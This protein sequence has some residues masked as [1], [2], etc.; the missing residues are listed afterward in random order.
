M[1]YLDNAATTRPYPEVINKITECV[2]LDFGNPSSVH[3]IGIN[4]SK[5]VKEARET[6]A[7]LF[8]VPLAGS[9]FCGSGT[10]ADNL[11]I[12]GALRKQNNEFAGELITSKTEHAA[13]LK[14]AACLEEGGV[15][16]RILSIDPNTGKVELDHLKGLIT[17][18][19][20]LISIQHVNSETGAIHDLAAISKLVKSI[21]SKTLVH[22]D[23]V[24]AF[25]KFPVHLRELGIDM[26]SISGHKFGGVK[27]AGALIL[28][29]NI[30]LQP[31]IH[32]G[33]Q[34]SG[35]RSGTENVSGV[36]A[37]SLAAKLSCGTQKEDF[38]KVLD[39]SNWFKLRL[40]EEIPQVRI[41]E[42]TNSL[43]HILNISFP[44]VLGEVLLHHL[45]GK[46]IFLSTGSA[47]HASSKNLSA[48]LQAL[49]FTPQRI[50]E[51]IRV[52][53]SA[54]E[55]PQDREEFLGKFLSSVKELL[56]MNSLTH[57]KKPL[58]PFEIRDKL[59][60]R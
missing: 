14:T 7:K 2:A 30:R 43:P 49:N 46:G 42:A 21:N 17:P 58:T 55:L 10:E 54:R 39:F 20:R 18:Q 52:S 25:T 26:Y 41:Y 47:C 9:V 57:N 27:G 19:T 29:S 13:I 31:L 32:G 6:L 1:Y 60:F 35:I 44:S 56:D 51:T 22:S 5:H 50:R 28:T 33:G 4:A 34:E 8:K 38:Q 37:L 24:Q 11:A 59:Q 36:A 40:R 48:A 23:G 3:P 16:V 12:L 45:A 53:L 15:K